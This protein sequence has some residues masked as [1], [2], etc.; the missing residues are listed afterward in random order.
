[1]NSWKERWFELT[2]KS[3]TY[4]TDD[5]LSVMKGIVIL[6]ANSSVVQIHPKFISDSTS[7]PYQS[8]FCLYSSSAS[9]T[10]TLERR[11]SFGNVVMGNAVAAV[12][13]KRAPTRSALL[14]SAP[15]KD[16]MTVWLNVLN[17]CILKLR[18]HVWPI[19]IQVAVA[20]D[21]D[22][23]IYTSDAVYKIHTIVNRSVKYVAYH[24]YL[25]IREVYSKIRTVSTDDINIRSPFPRA[26][27]RSTFGIEL[28]AEE[29]EQRRHQLE[30]YLQEL[31]GKYHDYDF[32][33]ELGGTNDVQVDLAALFGTTPQHLNDIINEA[34]TQGEVSKVPLSKIAG[35]FNTYRDSDQEEE[36]GHD[37]ELSCGD[38]V[39]KEPTSELEMPADASE[40]NKF[41][42][43]QLAMLC[44]SQ[45]IDTADFKS[46]KQYIEALSS[47]YQKA[48]P[49]LHNKEVRPIVQRLVAA[50]TSGYADA[51]VNIEIDKIFVDLMRLLSV[52]ESLLGVL[53]MEYST[54]EKLETIKQCVA[55]WDKDFYFT[56]EDANMITAIRSFTITA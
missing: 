26:F 13:M 30:A 54:A 46:K 50:M 14:L 32:L 42:V 5:S 10:S 43:I 51:A 24:H 33:N 39:A 25:D 15:D 37:P 8:L 17:D 53:S 29:I 55:V 27:K 18:H 16:T 48:L 21:D 9:S 38:E 40:L 6:T 36:P 35:L 31:I 19:V 28:G 1:M 23:K 52:C 44:D 41:N 49:Y 47:T 11:G 20:T 4:F 3:L 2:E 45:H 56:E 12:G 34:E 7:N 22:G